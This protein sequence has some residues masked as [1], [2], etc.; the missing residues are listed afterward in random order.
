MA[1][2]WT[3]DFC[4]QAAIFFIS[5]YKLCKDAISESHHPCKLLLPVIYSAG[6]INMNVNCTQLRVYRP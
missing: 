3:T 4:N 2:F 1:K 5:F 6:K